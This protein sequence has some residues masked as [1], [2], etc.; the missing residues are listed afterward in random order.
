MSETEKLKKLPVLLTDEEAE[1]F[2]DEDDL[3][4]Y[5][6][7]GFKPVHFEFT[8]EKTP[9]SLTALSVQPALSDQAD[10]KAMHLGIPPEQ[11]M[12]DAIE[13]AVAPEN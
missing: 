5:D 13:R 6:L 1:R 11:F 2:V 12:L 7:S 4:E 3:S 9:K 8:G 10:M